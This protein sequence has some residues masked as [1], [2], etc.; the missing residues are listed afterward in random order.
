M[1]KIRV[2]LALGSS[3]VRDA[4]HEELQRCDRVRVVAVVSSPIE[5]LRRT[6]TDEAD[7]VILESAGEGEM[8]GVLTHLFAEFPRLTAVTIVGPENRAVVYRQEIRQR[9]YD[10]LSLDELL[11]ELTSADTKYWMRE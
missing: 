9:A 8:P 3:L 11:P 2:I 4:L 10:G 1:E 6:E 7:A 5:L